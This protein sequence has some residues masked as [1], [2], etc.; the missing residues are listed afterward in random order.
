MKINNFYFVI[1]YFYL[2]FIKNMNLFKFIKYFYYL[3]IKLI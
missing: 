3:F 1:K 2:I